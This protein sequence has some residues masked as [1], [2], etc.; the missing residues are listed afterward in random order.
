MAITVDPPH[1]PFDGLDHPQMVGL[2]ALG[3]PH[4]AS[5]DNLLQKIDSK[6]KNL[7]LRIGLAA[8]WV[9]MIPIF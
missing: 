8:F 7:H 3:G 5:C 4:V 6:P 9:K 2:M 1:Q